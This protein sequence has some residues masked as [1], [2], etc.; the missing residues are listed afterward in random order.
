MPG[1]STL[2]EFEDHINRKLRLFTEATKM[3]IKA[4]AN[5]AVN[6]YIDAYL[7]DNEGVRAKYE[8]EEARFL[9]S[10][11]TNIS[12]LIKARKPKSATRSAKEVQK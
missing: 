6:V 8:A 10:A 3:S 4:V 1:K 9:A 7:H 2:I 12:S 5:E 11:G